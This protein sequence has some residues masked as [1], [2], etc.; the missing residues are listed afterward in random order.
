MK[1]R[2]ITIIT[3]WVIRLLLIYIMVTLAFFYINA[4]R[5]IQAEKAAPTTITD[6]EAIVKAEDFCRKIGMLCKG[7]PV[8][9]T[10][11]TSDVPG[12]IDSIDFNNA[13]L[14]EGQ[15]AGYTDYFGAYA[16]FEDKD[17]IDRDNIPR[18][19][20]L[21]FGRQSNDVERYSNP[22]VFYSLM[23]NNG[24]KKKSNF[25]RDQTNHPDFLPEEKAKK[26]FE[27]VAEKIKLPSDMFFEKLS[28]NNEY[29]TWNAIWLRKK[30]GQRYEGDGVTMSIMGATGDFIKYEKT[31]RGSPCPT[32]VNIS[33]D[34][35]IDLA[36]NK[37][38]WNVPLPIIGKMK[39]VY[40]INAVM[41]I[42]PVGKYWKDY[43]P[44]KIEGS[45]LAWII[46]FRFTG[47]LKT[48]LGRY[49]D[50][51]PRP[52]DVRLFQEYRKKINERRTKMWLP[53]STFEVRIDAG[54]GDIIYV[55][56]VK[57]WYLRWYLH[58]AGK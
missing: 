24:I 44:I 55:S 6:Q 13:H 39:E 9:S 16:V 29:G 58:W 23:R 53:V 27:S 46:N 22:T 35:A 30:D 1:S 17:A 20:N 19:V 14:L 31:Y 5:R 25:P 57:P 28:K 10:Q 49:I 11:P 50:G 51:E 2:R 15:D 3:T 38:R 26:I 41:L 21:G 43:F 42:V 33:K 54:S 45:R 48:D 18:Y 37:L 36:W 34:K 52:D 12:F 47:G 40:E 8:V 32:D 4:R 7:D 56:S